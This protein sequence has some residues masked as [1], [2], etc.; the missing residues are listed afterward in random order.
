MS[1]FLFGH[2]VQTHNN[3]LANLC[4]GVGERVLFTDRNLTK[5]IQPR[6][7][8]FEDKLASYRAQL[9]S[10]LGRQSPVTKDVFPSFYKGPRRQLYQR[11]VDDLMVNQ[12]RP[13]DAT[14]KTFVK[15]EKLNFDLKHDPAPRVIQPRSPRFNV[16]VGVYLRPLEHKMY[17]A[18]DNIFGNPTIMSPYNAYRQADIIKDAF[19][20]F[21]NPVCIGL[22]ASRFDQHVSVAALEFEHSIYN[23]L[24]KSN[25]L[26]RL[27]SWQ[28]NNRG[29]ARASDGW[30][31]YTKIGSRMSGD[32]NTSMGNKILM[33]LMAKSFIDTKEFKIRFLNNGDDCLMF[34]DRKNLN[35]VDDLKSYMRKFG[36]NIVLEKPVFELEHVEFCQTKPVC[37]NQIWRMVR[38]IRS[39]LT[40]D[41]TSLNLG[42]DVL[43]Y[44]RLLRDIGNCGLAFAADVPIMG[45]FYRMLRRFGLEGRYQG[46]WDDFNYYHSASRS[47]YCLKDHPDDYGRY[48]YWKQTGISP[49]AQIE[50]ERY[51]DS[52]VWGSDNH[53]VINHLFAQLI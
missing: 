2:N 8:R 37:V 33:C 14:L 36:F 30:F 26:K 40:K 41:V 35:D 5:P 51:F 19:D 38:N 27:L 50:M 44:R 15:A 29:V 6:K 11:A 16:E 4:R 47:S 48:S 3:T 25:N 17:D 43:M 31:K 24:F 34:L 39:C 12:V 42:H 53:Q 7:N 23:S 28:L 10:V 22:D 52:S 46:K 20:S 9:L 21:C 49:D 18:I 1:R 13:K 45:N 32:M